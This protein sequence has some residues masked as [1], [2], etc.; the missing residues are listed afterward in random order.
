MQPQKECRGRTGQERADANELVR[1]FCVIGAYMHLDVWKTDVK[2][3]AT[4]SSQ[5]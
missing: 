5:K 3:L 4:D 1:K 2:T